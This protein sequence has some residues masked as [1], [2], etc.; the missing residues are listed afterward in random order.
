MHFLTIC[1]DAMRIRR[2]I[3]T[4]PHTLC[5]EH[6]SNNSV[7]NR[8]VTNDNFLLALFLYKQI[9]LK[10]G[11]TQ[12]RLL[13]YCKSFSLAVLLWA[14]NSEM[15]LS[16]L[17]VNYRKRLVF[18]PINDIRTRKRMPRSPIR[19]QLPSILNIVYL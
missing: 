1:Y 16:R 3:K 12:P 6:L 13:Q 9:I 8:R 4:L 11:K 19:F 2:L 17:I 7:A 10:P 18:V 14:L 15:F 5:C